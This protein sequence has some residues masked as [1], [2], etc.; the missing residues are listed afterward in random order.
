[1]TRAG[2]EGPDDTV[3]NGNSDQFIGRVKELIGDLSV[4]KFAHRAELNPSTLQATLE[5]RRPQMDTLVAI[6]RAGGV[7]LDW[8]ATGEGP[9]QKGQSG[10]GERKPAQRD[11][12]TA[13]TS[14]LA[15]AAGV[16]V[17]RV[18]NVAAS[19]ESTRIADAIVRSAL[20][21]T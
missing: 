16:S 9:R 15:A 4:R 12:A 5:G 20:R 14:A 7:T 10:A 6:A 18:H 21:Q 19:V 2:E 13:A 11:G 3:P 1:M 17:V 8:L